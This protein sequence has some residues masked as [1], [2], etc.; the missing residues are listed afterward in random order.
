MGGAPVIAM[1]DASSMLVAWN[2]ENA[3]G[4]TPS[5]FEVIDMLGAHRADS[6]VV[7]RVHGPHAAL[8]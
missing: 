3:I 5:R 8:Q 1:N 7:Q 2:S 4:G 6:L